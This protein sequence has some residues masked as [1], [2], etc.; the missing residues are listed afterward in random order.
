MKEVK[1][2]RVKVRVKPD[3]LIPCKYVWAHIEVTDPGELESLMIFMGDPGSVGQF[4]K[5][6][7][8][9]KYRPFDV[10]AKEFAWN[11][12]RD[13]EKVIAFEYLRALLQTNRG[14]VAMQS[15]DGLVIEEKE[16]EQSMGTFTDPKQLASVLERWLG[17]RE[18]EAELDRL[19]VLFAFDTSGSVDSLIRANAP[20]REGVKGVVES[21]D[22][23]ERFAKHA[24]TFDVDIKHC[25]DANSFRG[26]AGYLWKDTGAGTDYN[27]LIEYATRRRFHALVIFTDGYC[28]GKLPP[29]PPLPTTWVLLGN[30][31]DYNNIPWGNILLFNPGLQY[32]VA[33]HPDLITALRYLDSELINRALDDGWKPMYLHTAAERWRQQLKE[34]KPDEVIEEYIELKRA[35]AATQQGRVQMLEGFYTGEAKAFLERIQENAAEAICR[36]LGSAIT[37]AQARVK[38]QGYTLSFVGYPG[39]ERPIIEKIKEK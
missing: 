33:S 34:E 31:P 13:R 32:W 36:E 12:I 17:A 23:E 35:Q 14:A 15:L 3:G 16:E 8:S 38:E 6:I 10:H 24:C 27:L 5:G 7:Q 21:V 30:T 19:R 22:V 2:I 18:K 1:P 11:W 4:C 37:R 25:Y 28:A 29:E 20:I 9:Y 26:A 39:R